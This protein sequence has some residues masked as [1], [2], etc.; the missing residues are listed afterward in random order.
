MFYCS[1]CGY[2]S[3]KWFGKCPSCST[4]DSF[5]QEKDDDWDNNA[6]FSLHI[7]N[8]SDDY[9]RTLRDI[10]EEELARISTYNEEF[11]KVLGGGLVKGE[12]ILVGGEP[13]VGKSTLLLQIASSL[14]CYGKVL[15]L[16]GEES[17]QQITM[18]ARRLG[19]DSDNLYIINEDN[20][21]KVVNYIK[22]DKYEFLIIDSIQVVYHPEFKAPRG[23]INQIKGCSS[24]L[25]RVAKTFNIPVFIIGHVTKEGIISGPKLLEHI[26]DCVLYFEGEKLSNYR[27]IRA[28]K[29]RFGPTGEIGIFEMTNRG[30]RSAKKFSDILM[31][32]RNTDISG[33]CIVCIIE[34]IRPLLV[35]IQ[36]LVT[37]GS[38]GMVKRKV[39]GFDY[40]RFS[41]LIATI[42]KR[43]KLS[44]STE[45]VFLNV[46]G[47]INVD[48]PAADLGAVLSIVSSYKEQPISKD[49]VFI[50][51]VGLAGELRPVSN[52]HLRT[53][54]AERAGFK[55]CFLPA[56]NYSEINQN[57][58][59]C[60]IY[61]VHTIQEIVYILTKRR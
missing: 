28:V 39:S 16:S 6:I 4:W 2:K 55:K 37:K 40:N 41:L 1:N 52:I 42:E 36:A 38:F 20:L 3:V 24:F 51:E 30:L 17:I 58:F 26:V 50:G 60:E 59:S 33:S 22:D 45:D 34:G 32:H 48:D 47:G 46:A 9:P 54:E 18:R 5:V 11:D 44:L 13:G 27:I 10:K 15:Y 61:G 31:P 14:A 43:L 12:I 57:E 23:S 8:A 29:N 7:H 19:I 25:T 56:G 35:E 21:E 53:K 49:V